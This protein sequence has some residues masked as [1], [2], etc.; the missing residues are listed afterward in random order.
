VQAA[1]AAQAVGAGP[2]QLALVRIARQRREAAE[3]LTRD[4]DVAHWQAET[5]GLDGEEAAARAANHAAVS[6]REVAEYLADLPQ[7]YD[8]AKPETQKRI[9]QSLIERV[10]VL[11]P[12]QL[13]IYPSDE[14][15]ARGLAAAFAG[16][17]RTK[18]RQTGRGERSRA[19]TLRV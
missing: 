19:E 2:D 8:D 10:E 17:F 11:G 7:L 4:R 15:E 14:A 3:R 18:V 1:V 12:D 5:E 6:A 9:L 13:W 16:E